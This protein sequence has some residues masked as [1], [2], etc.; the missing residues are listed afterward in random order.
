M[1]ATKGL[2]GVAG[3]RRSEMAL[4]RKC[5][6]GGGGGRCVSYRWFRGN[7]FGGRNCYQE[8]QHFI[9]CVLPTQRPTHTSFS[10]LSLSCLLYVTRIVG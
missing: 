3:L 8:L 10:S 7:I 5:F 4:L 1:S 9:L 6:Q 2:L